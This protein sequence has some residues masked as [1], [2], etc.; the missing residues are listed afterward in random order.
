M[1]TLRPI[2]LQQEAERVCFGWRRRVLWLVVLLSA[3]LGL[4]SCSSL[5]NLT[6]TDE[7]VLAPAQTADP[8]AP[9]A[10]DVP[11]ND[12]SDNRQLVVWLPD[13][14]GYNDG[15]GAAD[16]LTGVFHQFEQEHP[17]VRI[18][19]QVKAESGQSDIFSY[20]RSAQRVAPSTLPDLV[21]IDSQHLWQMADLGLL[22]PMQTSPMERS[23]DFYQFAIDSVSYNGEAYGVPYA[24]DVM[25]L[26]G[27]MPEDQ[28]A[29]ATW[30]ELFNQD[31]PYLFAAAGGDM[32]ENGSALLQYIGAGG[33]L[34]EDG[35]TSSDEALEA[36]FD[37]LVD[38]RLR[39]AV[40]VEVA[41][42]ATLDSVWNTLVE[43]GQGFAGVS[44]ARY[45]ANREAT[46]ELKY[47]QA[48]TRNG[49]PTTLASNWA[50]AVVTEDEEQRA[51]ALALIDGLLD[52]AVQGAWSQYANRLPTQR[53]ALQAWS[54][55]SAYTDFLSRQLEV[56]VALPN[57]RAFS[58]FA[59]RMLT[60]QQSVIRGETAPP[61]AV[62]AVRGPE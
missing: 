44:A 6:S 49:L 2:V 48:P 55:P 18:D 56:A 30:S 13:F 22:S 3:I 25:H 51:L 33:Q 19:V 11:A 4:C 26:A 38:G 15:G 12:A 27:F 14:S 7:P 20:L 21:L 47:A 42:L 10:E 23:T 9:A 28:A 32:Y 43:L 41:E 62:E 5:A 57:G 36:V 34:L 29:P 1:P 58:D 39:G 60:A 61:D 40:P 31:Q 35:S 8:S 17:G 53:S 46:P 16:V 24:A 50:F 45:L 59:Q 54:N 52:P 37:F